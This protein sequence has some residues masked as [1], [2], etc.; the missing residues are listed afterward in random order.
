[1][2]IFLIIYALFFLLVK[3]GRIKIEALRKL[4]LFKI[5]L[6]FIL[7][8]VL[9][10]LLG[11][12]MP[13]CERVGPGEEDV[14][15]VMFL[16]SC[17][18][19]CRLLGADLNSSLLESINDEVDTVLKDYCCA[20]NDLDG[21]GILETA[22]ELGPEI[23]SLAYECVLDGVHSRDFCSNYSSVEACGLE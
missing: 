12:L 20:S 13:F 9:F 14:N 17:Q 22:G 4:S 18:T 8:T 15:L 6:L 11:F 23:C 5:I 21:D 19:E 1:M 10:T 2:I 7:L 16:S 3:K